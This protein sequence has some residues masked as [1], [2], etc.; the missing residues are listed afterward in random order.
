[1]KRRE[2]VLPVVAVTLFLLLASVSVDARVNDGYGYNED[3]WL[4]QYKLDIHKHS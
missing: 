3:E 1:M 2:K 4:A